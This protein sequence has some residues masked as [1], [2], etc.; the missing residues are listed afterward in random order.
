MPQLIMIALAGVGAYATYKW[1]SKQTRQMRERAQ[2]QAKAATAEP[3][4]LGSLKQ[5][6]ATGEYR[7]N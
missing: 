3:R 7:P 2:A 1:V 4:D 6:P 5:D